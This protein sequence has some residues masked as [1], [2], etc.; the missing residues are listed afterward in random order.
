MVTAK[1][2]QDKIA[3]ILVSEAKERKAVDDNMKLSPQEKMTQD[4]MI[5]RAALQQI[6][7]VFTP[8]QMAQIEQ[9]QDHPVASPTHP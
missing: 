1:E 8:E 3:P 9:G 2:Q 4:G 6:K 7:T 5:H